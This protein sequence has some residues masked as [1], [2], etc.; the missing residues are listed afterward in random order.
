MVS[1]NKELISVPI[2]NYTFE[3]VAKCN[4]HT[5]YARDKESSEQVRDLTKGAVEGV[6]LFFP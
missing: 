3:N 4:A 1:Y 2:I 6:G 5:T